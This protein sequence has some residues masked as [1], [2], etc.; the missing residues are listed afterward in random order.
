MA[1]CR[2]IPLI[3]TAQI[4]RNPRSHHQHRR[5]QIL[6]HL[7]IM[8][9]NRHISSP[10]EQPD[11]MQAHQNSIKVNILLQQRADGKTVASVLEVPDCT[12]VENSREQAI[13]S[14]RNNLIEKLETVEVVSLELPMNQHREKDRGWLRS[15]G[16]FKTDP[17][18]EEY[19]QEIQS[20]RDELDSLNS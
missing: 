17:Q 6:D 5:S 19:Q 16:I 1:Y 7:S 9:Y 10:T 12:A 15:A 13:S 14:L 8:P 3:I 4:D 18:F 20:Y 11:I 2:S